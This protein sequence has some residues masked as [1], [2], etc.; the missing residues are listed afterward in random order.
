MDFTG[1]RL[2]YSSGSS[3]SEIGWG[4]VSFGWVG[5]VRYFGIESTGCQ[6]GISCLKIHFL[7]RFFT[8][9][10]RLV[11]LEVRQFA[12]WLLTDE[13]MVAGN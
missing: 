3:G 2:P 6:P 9:G 5:C 10:S 13:G 4:C 8:A 12:S 1:C 11:L 7:A